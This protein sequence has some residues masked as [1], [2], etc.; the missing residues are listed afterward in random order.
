[1]TAM[2]AAADADLND[3]FRR[4]STATLATILT[5]RGLDHVFLY[6]VAPLPN[7]RPRLAGRA[8]T[9]RSVAVREDKL[10]EDK[11]RD[12]RDNLQRRA[13]EECPPG[14]VL[15]IDCRG[16]ATGASGGMMLFERMRLRGC[17]GVVTDGGVRDAADIV[18]TGFPVY[19]KAVC[20]PNSMLAHRFIELGVPITCGGVAVYPGDFIVGDPDGVILVPAAIAGEV[21]DEALAYE[22]K[23]AFILRR[24][25]AGAPIYGTYPLEGEGL[26]EY[27]AEKAARK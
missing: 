1:M 8:F 23:E 7:S 10:A 6:G 14:Q 15:V 21:A 20:P 26:A 24:L 22:D 16:D 3:R 2:S 4:C 5:R 11:A 18:E 27:E 17:A 19:A 9:L 12:P 25:R 13:T